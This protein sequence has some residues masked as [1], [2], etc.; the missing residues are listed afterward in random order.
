MRRREQLIPDMTPLIDVVFLLLIFFLVST[1]FKKEELALALKLPSVKAASTPIQKEDINIELSA[2]KIALRGET[3][4]F[5]DLEVKLSEV[6]DKQSPVNVRID[7]EVRYDRIVELFDMLKKYNLN[8]LALINE[9][10][11]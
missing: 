8:R 6:Q 10:A 1:V 9:S 5:E 2:T 11:K 7:K 3:I 4:T